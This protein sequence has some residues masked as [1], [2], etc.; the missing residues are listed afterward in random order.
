M[1]ERNYLNI[2][3]EHYQGDLLKSISGGDIAESKKVEGEVYPVVSFINGN[4]PC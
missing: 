4:T 3:T 1:I 2:D